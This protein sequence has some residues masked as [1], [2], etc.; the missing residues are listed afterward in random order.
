MHSTPSSPSSNV[1]IQKLSEKP[2]RPRKYQMVVAQ[3]AILTA[4]I[5]L[6]LPELASS[7]E[8]TRAFWGRDTTSSTV[9]NGWC[10]RQMA[11][12]RSRGSLHVFH[13]FGLTTVS[14]LF[15]QLVGS[16]SFSITPRSSLRCNSFNTLRR[17]A[18]GTFLGG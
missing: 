2:P 17:N 14:M 1:A 9:G 11:R 10:S 8:N 6:Y 15:A 18:A 3:T 12:F 16:D 4:I 13:L 7:I 5:K